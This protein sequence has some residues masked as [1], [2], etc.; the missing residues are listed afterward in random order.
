MVVKQLIE[1]GYHVKGTHLSP[2]QRKVQDPEVRKT[3]TK[4]PGQA[5]RARGSQCG[6]QSET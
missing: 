2:D 5:G 4:N 6:V 1:G 3:Y